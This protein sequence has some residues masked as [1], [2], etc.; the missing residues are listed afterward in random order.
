MFLASGMHLG[1][2]KLKKL[3]DKIM[4]TIKELFR[5]GLIMLVVSFFLIPLHIKQTKSFMRAIE[6][7]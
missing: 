5:I 6:K 4:T 2:R 1:L 3:E 7:A